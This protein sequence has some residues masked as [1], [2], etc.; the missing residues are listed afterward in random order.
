MVL[1]SYVPIDSETWGRAD[2]SAI[3]SAR[4]DKTSG[5]ITDGYEVTHN[6]DFSGCH[7]ELLCSLHGHLHNDISGYNGNVLYNVF[8]NFSES[9]IRCLYFALIDRASRQL[10]VWKVDNTPQ[11]QNYQIPLDKPETTE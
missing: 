10:N 8:S 6:F 5:A 4:R 9:S 7:G 11:Y 1:L 2:I 3:V